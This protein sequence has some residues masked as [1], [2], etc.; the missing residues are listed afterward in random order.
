MIE[1]PLA[2]LSVEEKIQVMESLWDDLC[3][4]AD[5]LESPSWHADIL[6]QRAADIAQGTE[7]FTDWESA[8]RAIR[9]RLP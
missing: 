7:Q 5:D 2:A 1:L 8:K 9:G 4:R 6:A 3:H